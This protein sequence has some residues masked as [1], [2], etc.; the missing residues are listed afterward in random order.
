M[1]DKEGKVTKYFDPTVVPQKIEEDI[2]KL[3]KWK[4]YIHKKLNKK[5]NQSKFKFLFN[6]NYKVKDNFK[7]MI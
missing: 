2:V 5:Q 1:L 3:L 6:N 7:A 4:L